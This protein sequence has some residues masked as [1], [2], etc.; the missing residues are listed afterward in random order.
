MM[1]KVNSM[2]SCH[3]SFY[4]SRTRKSGDG[5]FEE[6]SVGNSLIIYKRTGF[7]FLHGHKELRKQAVS[8][9]QDSKKTCRL[10][11]SI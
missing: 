4:S 8:S 1:T 6:G 3:G 5:A 11:T 7:F 2:N 10:E 9:N